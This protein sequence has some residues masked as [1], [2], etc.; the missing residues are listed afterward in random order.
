MVAELCP[1]Q[2]EIEALNA[3]QSPQPAKVDTKK[4]DTKKVDTKKVDTKKKK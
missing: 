1:T 4:V 3:P 2:A